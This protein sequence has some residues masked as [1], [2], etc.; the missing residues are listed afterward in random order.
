MWSARPRFALAALAA[1]LALAVPA[2]AQRCIESP[3]PPAGWLAQTRMLRA[4]DLRGSN[5]E[6][7]G[8]PP[9]TGYELLVARDFHGPV[10]ATL[11]AGMSDYDIRILRQDTFA[12][13]QLPVSNVWASARAVYS[14][15]S[16]L[17]VCP[18]LE[19]GWFGARAERSQNGAERES[20]GVFVGTGWTVAGERSFDSGLGAG[21]FATGRVLVIVSGSVDPYYGDVHGS[22]LLPKFALGTGASAAWRW[23]FVGA[24]WGVVYPGGDPRFWFRHNGADDR[25]AGALSLKAGVIF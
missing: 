12:V 3:L 19:V 9:A 10:T 6:D 4:P 22:E 13:E 7:V 25:A 23:L 1:A 11:T 14:I 8:A 21:L 24:E 17:P 18:L 20:K 16:R 5:P 2:E 15:G